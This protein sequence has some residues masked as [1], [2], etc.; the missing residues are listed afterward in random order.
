MK[1]PYSDL[2]RD[3]QDLHNFTSDD[4]IKFINLEK[5]KEGEIILDAMAGNGAISKELV[6]IKGV[7][8]FVLDNSE[9]QINEAK[10]NVKNVK[11]FVSSAL[12]EMGFMK[13]QKQIKMIFLKK[14]LEF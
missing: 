11:F 6:K 10:K 9:F 3:C 7:D 2:K 5:I 8:L 14:F 12:K 4:I 1:N 13:F